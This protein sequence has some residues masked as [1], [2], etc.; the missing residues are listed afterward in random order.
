[1]FT[2]HLNRFRDVVER[3]FPERQIY[4]RSEGKVSYISLTPRVQMMGAGVILLIAGWFLYSSASVFFSGHLLSSQSRQAMESR[5]KVQQLLSEARAREESARTLLE[6]RTAD[7]TTAADEF[8][9]RLNTLKLLLNHITEPTLVAEYRKPAKSGSLVMTAAAQDPEPRQSRPLHLRTAEADNPAMTRI[10]MLENE[11]SMVLRQAEETTQDRVE[12]LRA[13]LE[14]TG[15]NPNEF[16]K[17]EQTNMGGPYVAMTEAE[18]FGDALNLD[19]EFTQRIVRVSERLSEAEQLERTIHAAPLGVPL[20][21]QHSRTSKF[22]TRIDPIT[23]KPAFH[24]GQDFIAALHSPISATA[25]GKVVFAGWNGGYGRFVEI[26]H[27]KGFRSRYGHMSKLLVKKGQEV[28]QGQEIGL[29]GS[30][31][32]STGAHLHYEVWHDGRAVDPENF[33]K[34]GLYVQQEG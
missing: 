17:P 18:V 30:T 20:L 6:S 8:E 34:A 25:D 19:K 33:L 24:A 4:H 2:R 22:G 5:A 13:V 12:N 31:G 11:Q 10:A 7:F 27:G 14:F 3:V 15:L 28:K 26:D 21:V 29:M 1:M 16:V 23:G 9:T 32:R